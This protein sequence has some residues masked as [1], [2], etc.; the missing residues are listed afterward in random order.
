MRKFAY[1]HRLI[2]ALLVR[3]TLCLPVFAQESIVEQGCHSIDAQ[4]GVLGNAQ[5]INNAQTCFLYEVNTETVMYNWNADAP[6]YPAS[7]VKIMTALIVAERGTM[8]DA[9]TVRKNILDT[10]DPY[11][12]SANLKVD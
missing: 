10:V 4:Q 3:T 7:L 9:V 5:L 8:T 11:A 2:A 6:M 1:I 12:I